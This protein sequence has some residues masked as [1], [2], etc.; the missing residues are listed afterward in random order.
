MLK[1]AFEGDLVKEKEDQELQNC[2]IWPPK[3]G[4]IKFEKVSMKYRA[5][6]DYVLKNVSFKI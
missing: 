4:E 3:Q 5:N 2:E 6:L 1:I